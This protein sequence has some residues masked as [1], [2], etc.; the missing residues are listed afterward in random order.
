MRKTF[1]LGSIILAGLVCCITLISIAQAGGVYKCHGEE[2]NPQT[3]PDIRLNWVNGE[4]SGCN[5]SHKTSGPG[6]NPNSWV[7]EV[8]I[9]CSKA[10][11][12]GAVKVVEGDCNDRSKGIM[13]KHNENHTFKC[14]R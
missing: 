11:G 1:K 9:D 4:V 13:C 3:K 10:G 5:L 12:R 14:Y 7:T 8:K 6:V 2:I